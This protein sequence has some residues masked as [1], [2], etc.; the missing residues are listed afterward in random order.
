M[1]FASKISLGFFPKNKP[2]A[3]QELEGPVTEFGAD[4]ESRAQPQAGAAQDDDSSLA[5]G[6]I[7]RRK[8]SGA[9]ASEPQL[10]FRLPLIGHY[11]L[12]RQL[13]ILLGVFGAGILV[14]IL[15]LWQNA[16]GNAVSSA[17]TQIASDA[18]M[19]SQ[20]VGKAAPNAIQGYPEAFDQLADSRIQLTGDLNLLARGGSFSGRRIPAPPAG[21]ARQLK[22]ARAKWI[23][24]DNAAGTILRMKTELTGFGRTIKQLDVLSPELLAL[25]EELLNLKVQRGGSA[26]ELAALG[27]L[28]M[29]TQRLSRSASEFLS[30][31]GIRA[32]TAFQ[33]GR[34]S[35]A[36]RTTIEGFLNGN[37][38]MQLAPMR[39]KDMREK[40]AEISYKFDRYQKLVSSILADLP[41]FSAAKAA[42]QSI[43]YENEA[44]RKLLS[45]VQANFRS[46]Q[47]STDVW[48]WVMVVSSIFTLL[49]AGSVSRVMLQDSRIRTRGADVRR[50]EAE[51]MRQLSQAKEEEAKATNDQ[52]QAAILRLMNELQEVADGDLTV[53]ATVSED[54]TGAIADSVN[55][56]VEEL[57]GLVE[58]VTTTAEQV[59]SASTN[60]QNISTE[61]LSATEQQSREIQDASATVLKMASEINDVSRSANESADVARQSVAAAH[62][63]STAV[64][65]AI[66]GMHEI[67]EQIQ[68]TS[69][70]IKRLG[71][72][73]QEI[74]EITELI[75]DITEQTNVLALNAAI[76]AASAGEAG[77]GFSVVAE[78]VQRLAER[79][80]EAAK[81]IGALV[82]TIQTD[83]HD[84]VAAM[85]K[86]TQ[87]VV[88]G[89]RLSDAA[90]AALSDI[91]RVS[92][93][94]AEL[95]QGISF[96]T[97]LQATS[98]NGVAHN[99]QHILSVTEHTQDG[100]Q[101]TAQSI[102][103]LSLLAQE[104][105]NSVSRFRVAA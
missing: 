62:Q 74:G 53:H 81:Q 39:D 9:Q 26:R 16:S 90:G 72:S 96:A 36:F 76:Q 86:S 15:A 101:Q 82:R 89:A 11:S 24:S 17:Q 68:E 102:R 51:A 95:I 66:K 100:T 57:R 34:D 41:K 77:R 84:A 6:S 97:E 33:L 87:G 46:N 48:F 59:T 21:I 61:L 80:G 70:R 65:N 73:S 25:T 40:L 83:T 18:L 10:D 47:E 12:P 22:D 63:G 2:A 8:G 79:S 69:K 43:F 85:E 54:I 29:L 32:E 31:G 75:S 5:L 38:T 35:T 3:P 23:T 30:S 78:E 67:R 52:N 56:T 50:Q 88:E 58:R 37:D 28:M 93:R 104:L 94:L 45:N 27:R 7:M 55:Y 103:Q 105:K 71:E 1:G 92:N 4:A 60:A 14:T 64:E 20:R 42:E 13:R 44:I 99:I 49:T 98:A 19:H 91:S